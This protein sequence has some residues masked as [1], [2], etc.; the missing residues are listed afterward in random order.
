MMEGALV[1]DPAQLLH[2]VLHAFAQLR[3]TPFRGGDADYRDVEDASLCHRVERREDHLM[4]EIPRHAEEHQRVGPRRDVVN[5]VHST[6][7]FFS[8]LSTTAVVPS[9]LLLKPSG[10]RA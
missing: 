6:P 4:G 2:A 3:Q 10:S 5:L 7:S 1:V 8:I 9:A